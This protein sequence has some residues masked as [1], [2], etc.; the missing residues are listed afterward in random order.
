MSMAY[1]N[2]DYRG[3]KS[4]IQTYE[5]VKRYTDMSRTLRSLKRADQIEASGTPRFDDH[6]IAIRL[7]QSLKDDVLEFAAKRCEDIAAKFLEAPAPEFDIR[8]ACAE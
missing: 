3:L 6:S 5:M 8:K 4:A 1:E 2:N 7:D